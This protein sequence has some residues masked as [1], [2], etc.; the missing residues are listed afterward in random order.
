MRD[1]GIFRRHVT[2]NGFGADG[3]K[4][5]RNFLEVLSVD[6]FQ[7]GFGPSSASTGRDVS[8]YIAQSIGAQ[9][10][11]LAELPGTPIVR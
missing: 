11:A 6:V 2:F 5:P 8:R 9:W 3:E 1:V 7:C 10:R 4:S